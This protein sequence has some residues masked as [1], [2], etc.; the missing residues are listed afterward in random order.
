M[1]VTI[2]IFVKLCNNDE[3]WPKQRG[4]SDAAGIVK[5][6]GEA[7]IRTGLFYVFGGLSGG[8][9]SPEHD[10]LKRSVRD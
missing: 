8:D 1:F 5:S 7:R 6:G 2:I 9:V 10:H 4:W 3:C